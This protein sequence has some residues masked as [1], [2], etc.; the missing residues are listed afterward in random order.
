[1][2]ASS[3]GERAVLYLLNKGGNRIG[4][5]EPAYPSLGSGGVSSGPW[6]D[7]LPS[8]L[9]QVIALASAAGRSSSRVD[10]WSR[11]FL[12]LKRVAAH[13]AVGS[14]QATEAGSDRS[15]GTVDVPPLRWRP[16]FSDEK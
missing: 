8:V 7:L 10:C 15:A 13:A 14:L 11:V 5:G 1:M 16:G 2:K 4:A 12:P 3:F 6:P 9:L